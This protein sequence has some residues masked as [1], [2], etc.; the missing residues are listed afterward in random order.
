M[1]YF[2][3]VTCV[4]QIVLKNGLCAMA[5]VPAEDKEQVYFQSTVWLLKLSGLKVIWQPYTNSK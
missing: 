4:L 2:I 1:I 3:T 5:G